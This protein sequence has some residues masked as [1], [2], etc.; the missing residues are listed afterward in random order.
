MSAQKTQT[1]TKSQTKS[2]ESR[3][4][5]AQARRTAEAILEVLAGTASPAE[6]AAALAVSTP[7]YFVLE[8]RAIEGMVAGCEP[9]A[10][11]Y[12][13]TP[14]RQ[15]EELKR[16]QAKLEGELARYRALARAARKSAG[17]VMAPKVEGK[18]RGKPAVRALRRIRGLKVEEES[19]GKR[20]T[21]EGTEPCREPGGDRGSQEASAGGARDDRGRKKRGGGLPVTGDRQERVSPDPGQSDASGAAGP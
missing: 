4:A 5:S 12:A 17:V 20:T 8:S 10:R 18:R 13:H 1:K 2:K 21:G 15:I 19:D 7:R 11:G 6:A 3:S 9:K 14:E 16:A